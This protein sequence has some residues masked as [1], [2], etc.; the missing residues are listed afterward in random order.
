MNTI[1]EQLKHLDAILEKFDKKDVLTP[2]EAVMKKELEE[3]Y[4][5]LMH[6]LDRE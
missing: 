4:Q 2:Q 5:E 3:K 6:A 1:R